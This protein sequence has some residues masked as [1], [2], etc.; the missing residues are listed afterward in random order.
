MTNFNQHNNCLLCNSKNLKPLKGYEDNWL[1]KCNDCQFVFTAR[2]PTIKELID[3][4]ST[5]GRND[6][7][8]PIT[9][10]RYHEILDFLEPFRKTNKLIDVGCG[11]GHF[12]Q[13]ANERGWE[14][15][16]TEFTDE[17]IEICNKKGINMQ[18]GALDASKYSPEMFDVIVSFE[19][20]EHIYNPNEELKNFYDILRKGGGVY[21]TTPNFNAIS[22]TYLKGNWSVIEYPEH[23]SYYTAKTLTN[24]FKS[25]GFLKK[26]IQTTGVSFTRLEATRSMGAEKKKVDL[27]SDQTTDEKLR[28]RIETNPILKAAKTIANFI[29]NATKKGDSMKGL[30][31]KKQ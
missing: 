18:K 8:S 23:L 3:H 7:L 20:I 24:V 15:Y 31:V 4:Y 17:A 1:Q 25:H 19:V 13:I 16:G 6:Y 30:F 22:R 12:L 11:I 28:S 27:V 14:V 2:I 26:W 21:V 10:K 29:L 5:Y 9:V